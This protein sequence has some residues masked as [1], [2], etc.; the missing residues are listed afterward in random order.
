MTAIRGT[1]EEIANELLQQTPFEA[2]ED[3]EEAV[4][5]IIELTGGM[6]E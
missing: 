3:V 6:Q 5:R 1:G 2:F 4:Q